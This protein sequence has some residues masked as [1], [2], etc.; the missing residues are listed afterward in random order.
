MAVVLIL[1][2]TVL[3]W[4]GS[5]HPNA[6]TPLPSPGNTRAQASPPARPPSPANGDETAINIPAGSHVPKKDYLGERSG[7]L[8]EASRAEEALAF[9]EKYLAAARAGDTEA[10]FAIAERFRFCERRLSLIPPPGSEKRAKLEARPGGTQQIAH[11][12]H[13]CDGLMQASADDVG[14]ANGWLQQ[15][16]DGGNGAALLELAIQNPLAE[17][18]DQR[19]SDLHRALDTGDPQ[20]LSAVVVSA[21]QAYLTGDQMDTDDADIMKYGLILAQCDLGMSCSISG[22]DS[23]ICSVYACG[24]ATDLQG[25]IQLNL[26][27]WV[28]TRARAYADELLANLASGNHDWPEAAAMEATIRGT[29]AGLSASAGSQGQ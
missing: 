7:L 6:V 14:T 13:L 11:A 4:N 21:H 17:S 29:A 24:Q 15:A 2:A 27:P 8:T 1:G 23:A 20:V 26:A 18:V 25:T 28:Y 12:Q 5:R 10:Q 16:A 3:L 22:P 19:I 9:V